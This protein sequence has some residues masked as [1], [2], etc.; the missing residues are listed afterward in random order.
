[1]LHLELLP[2]DLSYRTVNSTKALNL[3]SHTL[4]LGGIVR[5]IYYQR[6]KSLFLVEIKWTE[7]KETGTGEPL[8]LDAFRKHA[9]DFSAAQTGSP[10]M[11]FYIS[12]PHGETAGCVS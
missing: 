11:C 1:M 4:W 3:I 9:D 6:A 8:R 2:C 7:G 5:E 10:E 12:V